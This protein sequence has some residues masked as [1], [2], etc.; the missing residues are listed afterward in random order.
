M[1]A[2]ALSTFV[3]LMGGGLAAKLWVTAALGQVGLW[4]AF[5]IQGQRITNLENRK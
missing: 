5:F 2:G 1:I 4:L 3:A